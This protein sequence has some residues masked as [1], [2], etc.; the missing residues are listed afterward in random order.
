M[1][2]RLTTAG[3]EGEGSWGWL[4]TDTDWGGGGDSGSVLEFDS[5]N[6]CTTL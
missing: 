1:T 3:R 2:E 4:Q 5:G 6:D